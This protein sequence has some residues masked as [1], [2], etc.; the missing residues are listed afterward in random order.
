MKVEELI[1]I[2]SAYPADYDVL[3]ETAEGHHDIK[4][5]YS[6]PNYK[7]ISL[8]VDEYETIYVDLSDVENNDF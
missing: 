7:V 2:L 8:T 1:K 4:Y 5:V 6:I 3:L